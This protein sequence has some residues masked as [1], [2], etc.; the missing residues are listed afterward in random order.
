MCKKNIF[1]LIKLE[2]TENI[3]A[4]YRSFMMPTGIRVKITGTDK[5]RAATFLG[6]DEDFRLLA[7]YDNGTCEALVSAD[8]SIKFD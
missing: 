1:N 2:N 7:K 4:L 5:D 3:I 8:V 6:I